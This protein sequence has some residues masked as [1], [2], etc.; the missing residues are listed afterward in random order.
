MSKEAD[1]R[2]EAQRTAWLNQ[3][4]GTLN[5]HED[6]QHYY[7][8]D[9]KIEDGKRLRVVLGGWKVSATM[10]YDASSKDNHGWALVHSGRPLLTAEDGR[11]S[12]LDVTIKKLDGLRVATVKQLAEGVDGRFA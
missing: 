2:I 7:S 9:E 11:Q 5:Y 1:E 3:F 8:N 4:Y 10:T 6:D 12:S